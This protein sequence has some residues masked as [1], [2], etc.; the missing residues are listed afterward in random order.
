M[1]PEQHAIRITCEALAAYPMVGAMG[2]QCLTDIEREMV[3]K[4]VALRWY[5]GGRTDESYTH[6]DQLRMAEQDM[7]VE[8][9][10]Q[11]QTS[12]FWG[13]RDSLDS[14]RS[15]VHLNGLL[16]GYVATQA[17]ELIDDVISERNSEALIGW[18]EVG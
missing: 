5:N 16:E 12:D 7:T 13:F 14:G 8:M 9:L 17:Q 2:F 6:T 4:A 3:V 10:S 11:L 15:T 18:R 1:T